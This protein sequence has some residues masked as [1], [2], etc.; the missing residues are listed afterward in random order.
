M[1]WYRLQI[2][3][4]IK[5]QI[6]TAVARERLRKHASAVMYSSRNRRIAV[7][8]TTVQLTAV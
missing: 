7:R 1:Y 4:E 2:K 6:S 5:K 8:P 3:L